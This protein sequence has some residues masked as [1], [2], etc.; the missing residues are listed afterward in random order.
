MV[1]LNNLY[2]DEDPTLQEWAEA[3]S[4]R[5]SPIPNMPGQI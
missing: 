2:S 4:K 5:F 3:R 1:L